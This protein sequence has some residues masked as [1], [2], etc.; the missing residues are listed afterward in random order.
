MTTNQL[1]TADEV[2]ILISSATTAPSMHNTQPWH[3]EVLGRV[4]DVLLDRSRSLPVED[5]SGRLMRIGLGA[6]TFNLR[7]AAAMLGQHTTFAIDPDPA[8]PDIV[9]RVFLSGHHGSAELAGLYGEL[10]RRHTNRGP[11][12]ADG[13]APAVF[14]LIRSAAAAEGGTLIP[15]APGRLLPVL[16][17]AAS[18]DHDDP[19]RRA[20]REQWI[21]GDRAEDGIPDDAL[22][23]LPATPAD[24]LRDLAAGL[25]SGDH[26]VTV[27]FE[28][29]PTLAVLTTPADDP[30]DWVTAGMALQHGLLTATSFDVAAS[31][32]GQPLEHPGLRTWLKDLI[33]D[34][35]RPQMII[36]LG[37][38]ALTTGTTPRRAW[39]QTLTEWQ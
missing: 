5:P 37:Y 13:I 32:L 23:P 1:L 2:G 8:R 16:H 14:D 28:P 26:R 35:G 36:R 4:V 3:F 17:E 15:I 11:M 12:L 22:G 10:R 25:E 27:E 6:A 31:F 33:G 18:L 24:W 39:R 19:Y 38:P 9:A 34:T 30:H 29:V 20:E 7:V 21:G